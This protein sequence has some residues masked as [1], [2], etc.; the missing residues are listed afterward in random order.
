MPQS[1]AEHSDLLWILVVG[2][3]A[4]IGT[5]VSLVGTLYSRGNKIEMSGI[6]Q[7]QAELKESH[8][9]LKKDLAKSVVR[10]HRRI[11]GVDKTVNQLVGA[12]N[13][14]HP[15]SRPVA[16]H[17]PEPLGEEEI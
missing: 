11:D 1:V 8:Q 17:Q 3:I 5:L 4:L 14:L 10:I 6:K 2:C 16:C 15:S 9:E 13:V 12:H 7:G